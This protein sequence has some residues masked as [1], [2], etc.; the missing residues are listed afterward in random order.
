MS[1]TF[2]RSDGFEVVDVQ[3]RPIERV[4]TKYGG[5]DW[6]EVVPPPP[7]TKEE[8]DAI[9]AVKKAKKD[10]VLA[11]LKITEEEFKDLIG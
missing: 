2:R 3:D 11:K 6:V 8:L 9:K 5:E 1:K 7:P 10:A 4:V